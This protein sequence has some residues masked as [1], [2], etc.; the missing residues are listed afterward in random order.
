MKEPGGRG[1]CGGTIL[2]RGKEGEQRVGCG[3]KR[4]KVGVGKVNMTEIK[5]KYLENE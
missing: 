5:R 3:I 1:T 4:Q 2:K